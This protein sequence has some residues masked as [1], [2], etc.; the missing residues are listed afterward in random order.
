MIENKSIEDIVIFLAP[1]LECQ[2]SFAI[3]PLKPAKPAASSMYKYC[4]K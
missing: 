4:Y 2:C 3:S 1:G